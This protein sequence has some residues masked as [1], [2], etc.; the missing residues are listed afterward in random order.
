M[1]G[2]LH[3]YTEWRPRRL[4]AEGNQAAGVQVRHLFH[5][6]VFSVKGNLPACTGSSGNVHVTVYSQLVSPFVDITGNKVGVSIENET[7]AS[8]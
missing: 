5:H 4:G 6:P 7:F 3:I 8:F 2:K 1:R